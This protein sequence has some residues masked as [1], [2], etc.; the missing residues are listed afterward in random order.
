MEDA[1]GVDLDWFWRAWFYTNDHVDLGIAELNTYKVDKLDPTKK[2]LVEKKERDEK[3]RNISSLRN[4]KEIDKTYNEIDP[5]LND[6]YNTYDPLDPTEKDL[7]KHET[8]VS[9]L[10]EKGKELIEDDLYYYELKFE[11]KGGI[12]MPI[13]FNFEYKDGTIET[14]RIPAEI[15]RFNDTLVTKVF[16]REKELERVVLD[17]YLETADI[18]TTNNYYPPQEEKADRFEVFKRDQ[19]QFNNRKNPMQEAKKNKKVIKS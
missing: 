9:K 1:S 15:W 17:P 3:P 18:N 8:R 4:E 11:K 2:S 14:V 12:V 16:P 5:S 19:D 13:I 7:K 10:T 6:F